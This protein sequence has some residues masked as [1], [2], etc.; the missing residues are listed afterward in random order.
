MALMAIH[1][2]DVDNAPGRWTPYAT[3]TAG[4]WGP[5]NRKKTFDHPSNSQSDFFR[6][7]NLI[8]CF[9][10]IY[11]FFS[12]MSGSWFLGGGGWAPLKLRCYFWWF[13]EVVLCFPRDTNMQRIG[14]TNVLTCFFGLLLGR[15]TS[16]FR[17][18]GNMY[19]TLRVSLSLDIHIRTFGS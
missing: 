7:E 9:S 1:L 3:T 10:Y 11:S 16:G 12:K 19:I 13:R 8:Q 6:L 5:N 4:W 15:R 2:D 17:M 14:A 18:V